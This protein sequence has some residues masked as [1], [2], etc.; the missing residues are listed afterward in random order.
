ML[1]SSSRTG[2]S[3]IHSQ[4]FQM[5]KTEERI[6][7]DRFQVV[8]C[9]E[10]AERYYFTV[11]AHQLDTV[12]PHLQLYSNTKTDFTREKPCYLMIGIP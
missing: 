3:I 4:I 7:V 6:L 12:I 5:R 10:A 11:P 9:E 2:R 8:G 1:R